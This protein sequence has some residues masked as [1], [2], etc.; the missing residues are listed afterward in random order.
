MPSPEGESAAGVTA[1]ASRRPP[2]ELVG[3]SIVLVPVRS[4]HV[5]ALVRIIDEPSVAAWWTDTETWFRAGLLEPDPDE[6]AFAILTA[7]RDAGDR[8]HPGHRG[9]RAGLSHMPASTCSWRPRTR[10][11]ASARRPSGSSSGW[12]IDERGHHRVTIDPAVANVRAI[13]AYE[14]VGFRRVGVLRQYER[15]RDGSWHDGLLM[16]LLASE[17]SP[18]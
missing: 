1:D 2:V 7:A 12:L 6:T 16:D 4:E 10:A 5:D 13:R 11:A 17:L 8:V 15:G 3:R 14:K 18:D 9:A